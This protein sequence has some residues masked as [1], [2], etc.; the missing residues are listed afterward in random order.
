MPNRIAVGF[1][2]AVLIE[3][4]NYKPGLDQAAQLCFHAMAEVDT[5]IDC[6]AWE[7]RHPWRL[8]VVHEPPG[9]AALPGDLIPDQGFEA[10]IIGHEGKLW[11]DARPAWL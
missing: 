2:S 10:R 1:C 3:T 9:M 5:G 6:A 4:R 11:V 7:R 8:L